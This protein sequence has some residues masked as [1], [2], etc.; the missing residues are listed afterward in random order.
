MNESDLQKLSA[1]VEYLLQQ[2]DFSSNIERLQQDLANSKETFVWATV[3]LDAIPTEL[4]TRIKSG[5]I[6]HLRQDVPSGAHYHPNSIQHMIMVSGKG[7]SIVGDTRK[8]MI[9]L[10][11]PD[12][13]LADK[14]Y[15]IDQNVPHEFFPE[16]ENMT[17]VSFHTCSANELEEIACE[18]GGKRLYEG[19]N[20]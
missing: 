16:G 9:S 12:Y 7:T 18:T 4:P 3:E 5:W 6:F 19:S 2:E 8:Q 17:V 20:A 11:A 14:W 10:A 13:A 15:V 1:A